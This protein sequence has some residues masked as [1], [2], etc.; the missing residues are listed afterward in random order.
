MIQPREVAT[1]ELFPRVGTIPT[2]YRRDLID[3]R[4]CGAVMVWTNWA[5]G[6]S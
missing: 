6:R 5:L 3:R 4:A 2:R 1:V